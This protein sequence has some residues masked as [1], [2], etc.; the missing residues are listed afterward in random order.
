MK[1]YT[2][3]IFGCA[4]A[5]YYKNQDDNLYAVGDDLTTIGNCYP[6][7]ADMLSCG[8]TVGEN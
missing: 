3:L 2:K 8:Q 7:S 1:R 6:F 5:A 4:V